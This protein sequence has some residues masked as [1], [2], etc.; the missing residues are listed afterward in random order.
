V[1]VGVSEGAALSVLFA[2]AHPQR[3]SSLTLWAGFVRLLTADGQG[4]GWTREFSICSSRSSTRPGRTVQGDERYRDWFVRC[5]RAAAGPELLRRVL[6]AN[7]AIDLGPV[8][9]R[10]TVPTL[11][12][13]R[14]DESWITI[15]HAQRL[16][17]SIP[18]ARLVELPGVD[19]WPWLGDADAALTEVEGFVT[20]VRRVRRR[21]ATS[22]AGSLT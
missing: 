20:G 2:V 21:R 18:G 17:A 10:V 15:D 12:I 7:T 5:A 14:V 11:V 6:A 16:A 9:D 8:L 22:G 13:Q 4:P 3:V 1:L 19:H